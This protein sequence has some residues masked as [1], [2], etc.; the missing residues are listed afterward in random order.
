MPVQNT[1]STVHTAAVAGAVVDG[2][3]KNV[4]T[5]VA[6]VAIPF[7]RFISRD[8]ADGVA[9]LPTATGEVTATGY[10]V[11]IRVQDD[12]AGAADLL[13]YEIGRNVSFIDFGVVYG[14]LDEDVASG[15]NVFVRYAAGGAGQGTFGDTAGTSER[16]ALPGAYFLKGGTAGQI[17]PIRI[18]MVAGV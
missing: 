18:R 8:A 17:V 5:A 7:G 13:Q 16:V 6:S 10:G 4:R 3:L 15:A 11:A 9:K 14:L 2:Q 1:Y 12:V